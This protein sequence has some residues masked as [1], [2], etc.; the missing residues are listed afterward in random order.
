MLE[1]HIRIYEIIIKIMMKK[2]LVVAVAM[3]LTMGAMA[4]NSFKGTVKYKLESVGETAFQIPDEQSVVEVKVFDDQA[5]MGQTIQSGKTITSCIDYG[6]YIQ[7]LLSQDIELETYTGD[8]KVMTKRT[9]EQA[10]IDSLT[11]PS[12]T[13]A[14]FEYVDGETKE[15]AGWEAK[16]ALLHVFNDEG[17]DNPIEFW[18]TP[19]IG[20][21]PNFLFNG[22]A[23]MPLQFTMPIG[24]GREMSYTAIEVKKGKVKAV[25]LLLPAG[26]KEVS[27]EEHAL[28]ARELKDAL[29]LLGE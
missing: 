22:I 3:L 25:D 23:G 4:Q 13:G 19:E 5:M 12:T 8:G 29:E 10:M 11:I 15:I 17:K 9:V 20:P 21:T 2:V 6:M 28:I 18:Y 27:D 7:Y 24:E 26:Y 14:Y 1:M 16:K